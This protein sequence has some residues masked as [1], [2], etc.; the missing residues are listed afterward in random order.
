[1]KKTNIFINSILAG[2]CIGI[3]GWVFTKTIGYHNFIRA[4]LFAI[5]LSLICF[6][7][8]FYL[9]TGKVCYLPDSTKDNFKNNLI[10]LGIGF[11]GNYL[12]V[13]FVASILKISFDMKEYTSLIDSKLNLTWYDCLIRGFMCGIL[14]Y[15]A[16][17]SYKK[18]ENKL[19]GLFILVLCVIVFILSGF[20]HSIAD[21][22][23]LSL[24]NTLTFQ[25][26]LN[27]ILIA[28][29][30][31]LGGMIIPIIKKVKG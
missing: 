29:G 23:Y 10:N 18:A 30:N 3:G 21:M 17:D 5:A 6:D 22:F 9:Y 2:L 27:I 26:I 19:N 28:I 13:L 15:F 31:G 24:D 4:F 25:S 16:V 14:I 20:E 11:V 12:G 1:M 7:G 8:S